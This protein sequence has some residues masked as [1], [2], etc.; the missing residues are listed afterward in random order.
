MLRSGAGRLANG[1]LSGA[2]AEGQHGGLL[3]LA[4]RC[5]LAQCLDWH[6]CTLTRLRQPYR[7]ETLSLCDALLTRQ[8]VKNLLHYLQE[9]NGEAH[10]WLTNY[11]ATNGTPPVD[12]QN[13]ARDWLARLAAQ[14]VTV[15]QDPLRA[16][17]VKRE[18]EEAKYL[19]EVSPRDIAERLLALRL[20][21]ANEVSVD[22]QKVSTANSAILL[23]TLSITLSESPPLED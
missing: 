18:D 3:L 22:F 21:I 2:C 14:P 17:M 4:A 20:D 6:A 8:A 16:T 15:L 9:T 7:A 19:R 12:S 10:L 23:K 11:C 1:A 5:A 13:S